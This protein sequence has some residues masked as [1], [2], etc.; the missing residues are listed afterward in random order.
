MAQ[1]TRSATYT[2]PANLKITF[3]NA[4]IAPDEKHKRIYVSVNAVA[5]IINQARRRFSDL[6]AA[7]IQY[8]ELKKAKGDVPSSM[9]H[10]GRVFFDAG[11]SKRNEIVSAAWDVIDWSDRLRK[12][13]GVLA[14]IKKNEAW[15][16]IAIRGVAAVE[17]IRHF[18]QHFDSNLTKLVE[19]SYPVMGTVIA[20]FPCS[21]G[22]YARALLASA[23]RY[24][25]ED[26]IEI[27]GFARAVKGSGRVECVVLSVADLAVNLTLTISAV[28]AAQA[29]LAA[30]LKRD[31]AFEWPT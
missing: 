13:L 25:A 17:D 12:V 2:K 15:Y 30:V 4:G 21:D 3:A 26:A 16:Q 7:L 6:E 9:S 18:V 14:G 23:V 29:E 22:Y 20:S 31:Y 28:A 27:A 19:G 1:R 11:Y 24:S 8:D 10:D 5:F